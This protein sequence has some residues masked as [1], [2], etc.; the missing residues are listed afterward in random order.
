MLINFVFCF[1]YVDVDDVV[2][3]L[4]R[5][6]KFVDRNSRRLYL[7]ASHTSSK[8]SSWTQRNQI[9]LY[10]EENFLCLTLSHFV[11]VL[12]SLFLLVLQPTTYCLICTFSHNCPIYNLGLICVLVVLKMITLVIVLF[13]LVIF[14]ILQGYNLLSSSLSI[15]SQISYLQP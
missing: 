9:L 4:L 14:R 12:R 1:R 5:R 11:F 7:M 15:L 3:Y 10:L 6:Q 13:A 8:S 2:V